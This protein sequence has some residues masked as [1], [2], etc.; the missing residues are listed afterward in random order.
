[1]LML[2]SVLCAL[3]NARVRAPAGYPCP[4]NAVVSDA[5]GPLTLLCSRALTNSVV[6]A[7]PQARAERDLLRDR[8]ALEDLLARRGRLE[9]LR[10]CT[11]P[12][13]EAHGPVAGALD[14][15]VRW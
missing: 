5:H 8:T 2:R 1:M 13:A 7:P 9:E 12:R 6:L 3:T 4:L 14:A 10:A 11:N 15:R